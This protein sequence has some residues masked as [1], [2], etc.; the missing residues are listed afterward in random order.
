MTIACKE[1]ISE[2]VLCLKMLRVAEPRSRAPPLHCG[3]FKCCTVPRGAEKGKLLE[4]LGVRGSGLQR[5]SVPGHF[6]SVAMQT[7]A[8]WRPRVCLC[9]WGQ[10]MGPVPTALSYTLSPRI[11]NPIPYPSENS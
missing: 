5:N 9:W 2:R 10:S 3:D 6:V 4:L 8:G 11:V 7:G 1:P